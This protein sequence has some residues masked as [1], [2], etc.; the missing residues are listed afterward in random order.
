MQVAGGLGGG[1]LLLAAFVIHEARAPD[2]MLPL[3]LFRARNFAV[4][5]VATLAV[6]AGLGASTF[7]LPIFLQSV[8]GYS[9]LEAGLTQLPI[10]L[11]MIGLAARFGALARRIGPRALMGVGP[12]VAGGGLL[13][14]LRADAGATYVSD[15][16]PAVVVFG[17]GLAMTVAPLTATVLAAADQRHAGVAS[18]I[19]NAVARVAGLL[20][21][22]VVGAVIAGAYRAETAPLREVLVAVEEVRERPLTPPSEV[23]ALED[24]DVA[25]RADALGREASV[26]AFGWGIGVAGGLVATGGLVS[27]AGIRN[28]RPSDR[29]ASAPFAA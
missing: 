7:Y 16:L 29:R 3:S 28:P 15:V 22:A 4:G 27:L 24:P 18:G 14:L 10:T 5:N 19:N 23:V 26:T 1:M 8:A 6:Y 21:I 13:L 20:A 25:A 9:A 12:L 2:P 17:V 11:L